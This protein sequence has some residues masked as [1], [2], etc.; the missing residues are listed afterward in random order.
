MGYRRTPIKK[1]RLCS[2]HA[3]LEYAAWKGD[4]AG[5]K[6]GERGKWWGDHAPGGLA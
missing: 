2:L 5:G 1:H 4:T 3:T 6:K